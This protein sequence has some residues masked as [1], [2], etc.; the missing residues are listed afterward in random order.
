M[1][2]ASAALGATVLGGLG[3]YDTSTPGFANITAQINIAS[4]VSCSITTLQALS[5]GMST[6]PATIDSTA[7][8]LIAANNARTTLV[9]DVTTSDLALTLADASRFASSGA[10]TIDLP[11]IGARTLTS[12][13]I[14]YYETKTGNTLHL[15]QRGRD[16]TTAKAWVTGSSVEMR[17]TAHHHNLLASTIIALQTEVETKA[18]VPHTHDLSQIADLDTALDAKINKSGDTMTGLLTLSGPPVLDNHAATKAWVESSSFHSGYYNVKS[19]GAVG[20]GI[21]DDTAAIQALMNTVVANGGGTIFFPAGVYLIAGPLQETSDR[22]AQLL[23]PFVPDGQEIV[24]LTL[25]GALEPP[26]ALWTGAT[27]NP[28]G[29]AY[30]ILKSTLTGASGTASMI[31]GTDGENEYFNCLTVNLR[32]LIF[33]TPPNPSF[34]VVNLL[35]CLQGDIS[36]I[37]IFPGTTD[38]D[39]LAEPTHTNSYALKLPAVLHS[40]RTKVDFVSIVGFRTGILIGE[41]TDMS[42]ILWGCVTAIEVPFASHASIISHLQIVWCAYG[43]LV[44]AAHPLIILLLDYEH[45]N[46]AYS[47]PWQYGG[48]DIYDPGNVLKGNARYIVES[49]GGG[50]QPLTKVGGANFLTTLIGT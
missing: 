21:T 41:A 19:Y 37:F 13:E 45:G 24:N 38:L 39:A 50:V 4:T 5:I 48:V 18:D 3:S 12:S 43:L 36:Q 40:S 20:D 29:R 16:G 6:Y 11:A 47:L 27:A 30:S 17:S 28:T 49:A 34:T 35:S 46:A 7:N 26:Q 10:I 44:A 2:L 9:A 22:N 8:L 31:A 32:N 14:A 1:A 23:L 33:E 25:M 42:A 15:T